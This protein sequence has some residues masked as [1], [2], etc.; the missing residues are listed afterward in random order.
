MLKQEK[1]TKYLKALNEE[2]ARQNVTGELCLFGG[3]VMCLVY[4]ARP[5]TKD[6]DA[7]FEPTQS[8]RQAAQRVAERF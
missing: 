8:I 5:S 6:V 2:L 1:I 4:E 3:T 7:I